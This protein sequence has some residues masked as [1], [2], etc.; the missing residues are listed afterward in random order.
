VARKGGT[1]FGS[2]VAVMGTLGVPGLARPELSVRNIEVP[3]GH[4]GLLVDPSAFAAVSGALAAD[5]ARDAERT[6]IRL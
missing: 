1:P 2:A 5:R 6:T 4:L 3:A